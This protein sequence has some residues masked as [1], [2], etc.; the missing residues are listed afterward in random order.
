VAAVNHTYLIKLEQGARYPG[1]DIIAKLSTEIEFKPA[2]FFL[3]TI[4]HR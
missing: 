4:W 1:L 2:E 3:G